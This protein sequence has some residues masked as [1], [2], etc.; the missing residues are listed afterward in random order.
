MA[1]MPKQTLRDLKKASPG[2]R[3]ES[4]YRKRH[5]SRGGSLKNALFIF[6]GIATI[7]TGVLT[8]PI[9]VIPSEVV[10]V[11]GVALLAQ[12]SLRG[13]RMLDWIELRLRRRFSWALQIWRPLP[14]VLKVVVSVLWMAAL[15]AV[16]YAVYRAIVA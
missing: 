2:K 12:G 11:L 7:A 1:R 10:I 16:S 14:R 13:A 8:Y 15:S 4:I 9:P 3:F 6:G 5:Q